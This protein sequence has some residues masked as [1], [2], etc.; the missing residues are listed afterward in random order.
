[1]DRRYI[2]LPLI[3]AARGLRG[4]VGAAL[5]GLGVLACGVDVPNQP[6]VTSAE[7]CANDFD[8]CVMPV[9]SGQI[10][11]R[12]GAIV[13]CT[14]SN[15]HAVGGNG[16][17][18]TLGTDNSVNFLVAKSFVNFTSPHDS[19]LL[20]EPT[21][22][23]V[24]PSTVAAFHGGGEIFPSRTDACYLTIYNWISNQI[25]NQSTTGACGCTPVAST[26]ASCG[27]PP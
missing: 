12:G 20:V 5:C 7:L 19:L 9:L 27:Y 15:C 17:R 2:K 1:M 16:G 11:R 25:P 10:R 24:S 14:D 22:D 8:T 4:F 26:F 21:Q 18:F 3:R 6:A 13:S 23:D